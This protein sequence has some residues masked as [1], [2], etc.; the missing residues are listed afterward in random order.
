MKRSVLVVA[1]VL[2]LTVLDPRSVTAQVTFVPGVK[3]G[4]SISTLSASGESWLS[5]RRPALGAFLSINLD[6]TVS[7]QPEVYWLTKGGASVSYYFDPMGPVIEMESQWSLSYI[8][9]P[10]L[11]KLHP[12]PRGT[13]RPVLFAG[14]AFDILLRAVRADYYD[15]Q[16]MDDSNITDAYKS[17]GWDI[18]AGAGL[19]VALN[20]VMLVA[21]ARYTLGLTNIVR[22]YPDYSQKTRALM[23]VVGVGF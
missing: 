22:L 10:V 17:T 23:F 19:E 4:L 8:H 15:G 1:A 18:V 16:R 9:L 20:K 14:P 6:K 2:L 11:V 12:I 21:E 3:G 13:F 7:I 5:L